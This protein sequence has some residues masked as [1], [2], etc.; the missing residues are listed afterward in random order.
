MTIGNSTIDYSNKSM[1][2]ITTRSGDVFYLIINSDG[3]VYFLNPVDTADLTAML[4]DSNDNKK[5]KALKKVIAGIVK[6]LSS[7]K[8]LLV[9]G[10]SA[11]TVVLIAVPIILF[12][13]IFTSEAALLYAL[14]VLRRFRL[15]LYN[16]RRF[17]SY[18]RFL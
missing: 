10:L 16:L 13:M 9:M 3:S 5:A 4:S 18:V 11:L 15:D 6:V 17:L 7:G 12:L 8:V 2:T 14:T 1:Y